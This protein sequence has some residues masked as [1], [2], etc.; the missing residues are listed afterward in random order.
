MCKETNLGTFPV[1][2]QGR[3][4]L[5]GEKV[6]IMVQSYFIKVREEGRAVTSCIVCAAACEIIMTINRTRLQEFGH[7]INLNRY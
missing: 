3:L 2:K 6:D 1:K 4:L 7:H 5:L